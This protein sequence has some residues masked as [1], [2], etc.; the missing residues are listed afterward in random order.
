MNRQKEENLLEK[1]DNLKLIFEN[2]KML[3]KTLEGK[4]LP[5]KE[6]DIELV[7]YYTLALFAEVGEFLEADKTWKYWGN[8]N[9]KRNEKE[10]KEEL[11]D[12]F[13]FLTNL[14]LAYKIDYEEFIESYNDKSKKVEERQSVKYE[15]LSK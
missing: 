7:R 13:L 9:K 8:S 11:I 3:Q 6:V 2:Q 10:A 4:I 5:E 12:C 1:E 15:R 14:M